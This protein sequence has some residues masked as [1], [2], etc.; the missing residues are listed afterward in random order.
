MKNF[1]HFL[2]IPL[3]ENPER[4]IFINLLHIPAMI[5]FDD[6]TDLFIGSQVVSVAATVEE[7]MNFFNRLQD[8]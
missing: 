1:I 7:I 3:Y 2:R 6:H 5:G 4:Q 8:E